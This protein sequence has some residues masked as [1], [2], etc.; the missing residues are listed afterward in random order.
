MRLLPR[1]LAA[2]TVKLALR[3][4]VS[5]GYPIDRPCDIY[6]TIAKHVT[7]QFIDVP[8]LEGMYL[9]DVNV[10]RICICGVRPSGRQR[11]T[12]AHELGH[13]LMGHGTRL[14]VIEE[15]RSNAEETSLEETLAD[16]FAYHV[17]MPARAVHTGFTERD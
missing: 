17:L 10:R 8:T 4:R 6:R 14:D 15:A 12:G 1:T 16:I 11:L 5:S 7:L 3:E 9:E 13:L 2:E